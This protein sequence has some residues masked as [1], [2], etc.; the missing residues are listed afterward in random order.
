[1]EK[2]IIKELEKVA[3]RYTT[4][5]EIESLGEWDSY[6]IPYQQITFTVGDKEYYI[7]FGEMPEEL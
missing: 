3:K 7:S 4:V 1:M 6:G 2:E 5:E